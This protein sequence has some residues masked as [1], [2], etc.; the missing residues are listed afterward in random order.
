[1]KLVFMPSAEADLEAIGD[2]IAADNPA[3]A[4]SFLTE[5]KLICDVLPDMP[6]MFPL[7]PRYEEQGVRRLPHGDYLVFYRIADERVEVL[8]VINAARDYDALLFPEG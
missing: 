2:W 1:M 7:V 5:L 6:R 3:R 4:L 8:H